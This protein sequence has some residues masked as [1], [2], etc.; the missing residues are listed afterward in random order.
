MK[1][2]LESRPDLLKLVQ[3]LADFDFILAQEVL[4]NEEYAEWYRESTKIKYLDNGLAENGQPLTIE[5]LKEADEKVGGNCIIMAPDWRGEFSRTVEAYVEACKA[6]TT[7]RVI[8]VMQ[9]SSPSECLS[10]LNYYQGVIAVPFRIL[11]TMDDSPDVMALRRALLISNIPNDRLVHLLGLTTLEELEWYENKPNVMSIDTGVPILM[12]LQEAHIQDGLENKSVPTHKLAAEIE[13]TQKRWLA[14][15]V[16]IATL[17][18]Y[19]PA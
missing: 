9:G 6:F 4:G 1:L 13:L 14:I 15:V 7:N 11:S 16:N 10:C 8:G 3:P 2:A 19:L 17:R 12:G 5:Q 18:R